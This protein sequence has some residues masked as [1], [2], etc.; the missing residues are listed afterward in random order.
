MKQI[1]N[2]KTAIYKYYNNIELTNTDIKELFG[3]TAW[4]S[5]NRLKSPVQDHM[6]KHDIPVCNASAVNTYAAY[7]VWGLDIADLEKRYA[8]LEKY[9]MTEA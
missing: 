4:A 9:G 8:K 1:Q 2:I 6:V 7:E 3:V 5:I